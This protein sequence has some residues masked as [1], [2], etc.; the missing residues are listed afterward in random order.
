MNID[1]LYADIEVTDDMTAEEFAEMLADANPPSPR[2]VALDGTILSYA[3][4]DEEIS[5]EEAELLEKF[6]EVVD[7]P[8]P[9][10]EYRPPTFSEESDQDDSWATDDGFYQDIKCQK[11]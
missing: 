2:L 8:D 11:E 10:A 9:E 7:E 5:P 3:S 1:E 4:S 6:I